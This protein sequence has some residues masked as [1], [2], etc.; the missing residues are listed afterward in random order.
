MLQCYIVHYV[1][2]Y[3]SGQSLVKTKVRYSYVIIHEHPHLDLR[4]VGYQHHIVEPRQKYVVAG[5]RNL[6]NPI[7]G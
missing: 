1:C 6:S 3:H 7:E 5:A 2:P 4:L